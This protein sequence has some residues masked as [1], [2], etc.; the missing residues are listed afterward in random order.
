MFL[1]SRILL[2]RRS[3]RRQDYQHRHAGDADG[4]EQNQQS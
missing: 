2:N 4:N 1:G 3:G